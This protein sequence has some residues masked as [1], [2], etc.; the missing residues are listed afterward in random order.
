K[1]RA[2]AYLI[3]ES[4]RTV[5]PNA[6]RR[7]KAIEE[8]TELGAGFKI[9]LRDLEI[10]GAGNILGAEQ[11]GHIEAVGDELYC[12]LLESAVGALTRQPEKPLFDCSIELNWRAYLPKDYVP[13]PRL[14]I[15]LYRRLGRLHSLDRLADFRQELVDRFG[16]LPTPAENLI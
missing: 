1:H 2:Y 4:N 9:A 16:P 11:S 5:T 14:K 12:A 15:E 13:A 7:L 6:V 8:F 10:R 3:L